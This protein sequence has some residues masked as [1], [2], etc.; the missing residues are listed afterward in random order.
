MKESKE[1]IEI[2]EVFASVRGGVFVPKVWVRVH[3]DQ[4]KRNKIC[5]Y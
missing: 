2:Y 4:L 5:F 1:K 3:R